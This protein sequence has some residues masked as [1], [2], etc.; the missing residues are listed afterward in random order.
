MHQKKFKLIKKNGSKCSSKKN[1]KNSKAAKTPPKTAKKTGN[2]DFKHG[3][4]KRAVPIEL[5]RARLLL[6]RFQCS[7]RIAAWHWVGVD[8]TKTQA[9][10]INKSNIDTKT[11]ILLWSLLVLLLRLMVRMPMM[12]KQ[13][14]SS[15]NKILNSFFRASVQDCYFKNLKDWGVGGR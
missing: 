9:P 7:S 15:K 4:C 6:W 1:S 3:S 13:T 14:K 2:T 11:W 10:S 5:N 8:G 12:Q